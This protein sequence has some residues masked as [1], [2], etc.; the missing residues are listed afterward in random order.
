MARLLAEDSSFRDGFTTAH[1]PD[2]YLAAWADSGFAAACSSGATFLR[3]FLAPHNSGFWRL[4]WLDLDD[5]ARK[6][7]LC[8][9]L[10]LL[11]LPGEEPTPQAVYGY[12]AEVRYGP[13]DDAVPETAV[14]PVPAPAPPVPDALV[15]ASPPVNVTKRGYLR[16]VR[17]LTVA[18]SPVRPYPRLPRAEAPAVVLAQVGRR[19]RRPAE[20]CHFAEP[21]LTG[22]QGPGLLGAVGTGVLGPGLA[23]SPNTIS[24]PHS[25][26]AKTLNGSALQAYGWV[27]AHVVN[28]EWS[29]G[30]WCT[31][32]T[33]LA[34][35]EH[36]NRFE[37]PVRRA[38]QHLRT[39]YTALHGC[40]VDTRELRFGIS[41]TVLVSETS[42]ADV[43][44]EFGD[45][46][47]T[48]ALCR[49][50]PFRLTCEA[51]LSGRPDPASVETAA[52]GD[53]RAFNAYRHALDALDAVM[54]KVTRVE[55]QNERAQDLKTELK[56]AQRRKRGREAT[57]AEN[58]QRKRLRTEQREDVLARFQHAADTAF[59]GGTPHD[60]KPSRY[61][62][63][64]A[65]GSA[66]L[67]AAFTEH[68]LRILNAYFGC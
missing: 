7:H 41:V 3:E 30:D 23:V 51:E 57:K 50:V 20:P 35:G 12:A 42:W 17:S 6:F 26:L 29:T 64:K 48:R 59:P 38:L 63:Y 39:C 46:E 9:P 67:G 66:A 62:A 33:G 10:S 65:L 32:L 1:A 53:G 45:D 40:G 11:S 21:R 28:S 27:A 36:K 13:A 68:D 14:T 19:H 5:T 58:Q 25:A 18:P 4:W 49:D 16:D 2:P 56:A 52:G 60:D 24:R 31:V 43:H 61:R 34:N 22:G 54:V 37:S 55:I 8:D 15:P 44:P 47:P